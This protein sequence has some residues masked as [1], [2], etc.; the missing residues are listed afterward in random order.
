MKNIQTIDSS[1]NCTF[2]IF[3]A[4]DAEFALL[5]PE[6]GQDI[7]YAEDLALLP[8][9]DEIDAACRRIWER[10]IR[11]VDTHGIHGTLLYGLQRYKEW[12]PEKRE[13][14]VVS[15]AINAAQRRL[16]AAPRATNGVPSPT[17][18][19]RV[20]IDVREREVRFFRLFPASGREWFVTAIPVAQPAGPADLDALA[21]ALGDVLLIDSPEGRELLREP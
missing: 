12:Y 4:T 15:S 7:Q 3:Q 8:G 13:D 21:R 16:F 20:E 6:P 10:P 1:V 14:A 9:Q 5:F 11:K 18:H 19:H 17:Y 2:S